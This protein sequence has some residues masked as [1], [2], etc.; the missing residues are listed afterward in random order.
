M[1]LVQTPDPELGAPA[2]DFRLPATSGGHLSLAGCRGPKGLL[3]M[4]ICNHCPYVKAILDRLLADCRDIQAAG[5]GVVA[6][7]S[8][9]ARAYP[10]D[11]FERMRE[12]ANTAGFPFPY[13]YDED[14]S[15]ARAYGAVCT[16][17]FFGYDA[18]L[19]LRFRGRLDAA[20]RAARQPGQARELVDAMVEI[21][22]TGTTVVPQYPSMGCSLK[23]KD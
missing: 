19:N 5:V 20:H 13:L 4:F 2:P 16:P 14:Q 11:S 7:S 15:V 21:A 23:W 6:I 1:A 8:N 18:D 3:V 10:E 22:R 12:L 17:D 9:D